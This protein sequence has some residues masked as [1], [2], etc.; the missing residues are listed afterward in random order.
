MITT[1]T[2]E[3]DALPADLSVRDCYSVAEASRRLRVAPSTI[4]A[5]IRRGSLPGYTRPIGRGTLIP[6]DE[7]DRLAPISIGNAA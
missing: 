1:T 5:S 4:Y 6:R 7:V 3:L 2:R